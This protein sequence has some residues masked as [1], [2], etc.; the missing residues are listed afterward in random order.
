MTPSPGLEISH[1]ATHEKIKNEKGIMG[2][3]GE[4]MIHYIYD[5]YIYCLNKK[6][7]DLTKRP[8]EVGIYL[9]PGI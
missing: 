9:E 3:P 6:L 1:L 2:S 4:N 7:K 8:E 5:I